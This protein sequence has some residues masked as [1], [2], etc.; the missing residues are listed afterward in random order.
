MDKKKTFLKFC[1]ALPLCVILFLSVLQGTAHSQIRGDIMGRVVDSETGEALE[2]VRVTVEDQLFGGYTD[3]NG[4]F[5]IFNLR[6]GLYNIKVS[7][8]GYTET[9]IKGV[10]VRSGQDYVQD[11]ELVASPI[12]LEGVVIEATKVDQ[13]TPGRQH[14]GHRRVAVGSDKRDHQGRQDRARSLRHRRRYCE[15]FSGGE[16]GRAWS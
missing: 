8:I 15:K 11:V 1:S 7:I 5:R 16:P 4:E 2:G 3:E 10:V 14:R 13:G 6:P 9:T 12:E